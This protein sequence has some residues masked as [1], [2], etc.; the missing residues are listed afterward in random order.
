[1]IRLAINIDIASGKWKNAFPHLR[2]KMEQA[3]ACA[4]INAK[5]PASFK[6]HDFEIN[7]LLASDS[8]VK[9][10]NKNWRGTNKPTNVLSFPQLS[11]PR[12]LA[13]IKEKKI[14][15]GDIALSYETIRRECR[16]QK[17]TLENHAIHLVVHGTLH[18][19]GYDHMRRKDA[20]N[21]EKLEC[22]ILDSLGYPDP[23]H[24]N[25]G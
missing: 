14:A 23:Y 21:M 19:L 5:K 12:T 8:A 1:M 24:E 16:E 15:L 6:K 3:A 25:D 7:I 17:K 4:F 10:L 9:K 2:T 20:E 22:D 11:S 13:R 18:L